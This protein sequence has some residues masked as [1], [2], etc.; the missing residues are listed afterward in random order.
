M[1]QTSP[2]D[3]LLAPSQ[4]SAVDGSAQMADTYAEQLMDELFED[5]DQILDGHTTVPP[6]PSTTIPPLESQPQPFTAN[7]M[8]VPAM[9]VPVTA[10]TDTPP[11]EPEL[12]TPPKKAVLSQWV[13]RFILGAACV[14][15]LVAFGFWLAKQQSPQPASTAAPTLDGNSTA[16]TVSDEAAFGEYLTRSLNILSGQTRAQQETAVA[17]VPPAAGNSGTVNSDNNNRSPNIIERVFVP[18]FQPN[19]TAR[20]SLPAPQAPTSAPATPTPQ[21]AANPTN[22]T[23][24][25]NATAPTATPPAAPAPNIATAPIPN[26]SPTNTHELVGILELGNRSAALFEIN[27]IPQRVYVGEVVGSSGWSVVSVANQEVIVRRNGDV[28]SIHIGQQF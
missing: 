15:V 25:P 21:A 16:P 3:Q 26:I 2:S 1:T 20:A 22:P 24:T 13:P 28:R 4:L 6:S 27:G 9:L 12:P 17:A 23:T 5:V 10:A 14:S 19:A 11:V 8:T 18:V 7:A